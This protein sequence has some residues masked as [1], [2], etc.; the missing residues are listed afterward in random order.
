MGLLK[1]DKYHKQAKERLLSKIQIDDKTGCW[2]WTGS[3]SQKGYGRIAY[4]Y[5]KGWSF[6]AYRLS[7]MLFKKTVLS[8]KL[9]I[10]HICENKRCCNPEHLREVTQQ[11]NILRGA[12]VIAVNSRKTH[13]PKDHEYT[14]KN[15]RWYKNTRFCRKC[16]TIR[17]R[18]R[19][20]PKAIMQYAK[21]LLIAESVMVG[22]I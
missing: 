20:E 8:S 6:E 15:T 16:E 12:S 22:G 10:D 1:L 17:G 21:N 9:Q 4:K 18:I 13:C 14:V 7:Y 3:I 19:Y 11:Q 5:A 2:N